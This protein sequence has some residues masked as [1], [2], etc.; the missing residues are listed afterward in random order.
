MV[1]MWVKRSAVTAG[2][3]LYLLGSFWVLYNYCPAI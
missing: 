2:V 3:A 1:T